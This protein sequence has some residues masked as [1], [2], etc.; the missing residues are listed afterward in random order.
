M[1][2]LQITSNE[3]EQLSELSYKEKNSS[4][5]DANYYEHRY[6]CLNDHKLLI[7][8]IDWFIVLRSCIGSTFYY[9][10]EE[11]DCPEDVLPL[12]GV[13]YTD[14]IV[15]IYILHTIQLDTYIHTHTHNH[16]MKTQLTKNKIFYTYIQ[17]TKI[18]WAHMP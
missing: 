14:P 9:H 16:I 12:L 18:R 5:Q 6:R 15:S 2:E 8:F 3:M 13:G 1:N 10:W 7:N 11:S 4:I 17:L